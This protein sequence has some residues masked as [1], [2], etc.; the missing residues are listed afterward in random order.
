MKSTLNKSGFT[1][2]EIMIALGIL[3]VGLALV[4]TAFPS[5]MMENK[6]SVEKTMTTLIGENAL[7]ICRIRLSHNDIKDAVGTTLTDITDRIPLAERAYPIARGEPSGNN[8]DWIETPAGSG[9][10]LPSS[11]Y[12]W[13]LAA[14]QFG[15]DDDNDYLL[16]IV[17]Y[18]KLLPDDQIPCFQQVTTNAEGNKITS[19]NIFV[20]SP[21]ISIT[22]GSFAFV[23]D[24]Q[25]NLSGTISPGNALVVA[26][27]DSNGNVRTG[28][29]SP[30]IGCYVARTNVLP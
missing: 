28:A 27:K 19:G 25:G 16:V 21:V 11:R 7:A 3:A 9:N 30:A 12:G 29:D 5:A 14:K 6:E 8:D 23:T 15:D 2:M 10:Y 20:G 17:P 22:D 1:L 24:A 4:S 13:L 26:G 18:R